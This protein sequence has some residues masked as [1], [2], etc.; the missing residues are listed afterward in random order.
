MLQLVP[1]IRPP[2][3][4]ILLAVEDFDVAALAFQV[5]AVVGQA[6]TAGPGCCRPHDS[7]L[8]RNNAGIGNTVTVCVALL[9]GHRRAAHVGAA[10]ASAGVGQGIAAAAVRADD[11]VFLTGGK[12]VHQLVRRALDRLRRCDRDGAGGCFAAVFR[13]N[14][15]SRRTLGDGRDDAPA[16]G[17]DRRIAAGPG[18]VLIR[19]I[20]RSYR[21]AQRSGLPG[22]KLQRRLIQAD[23]CDR[24][25]TGNGLHLLEQVDL[26]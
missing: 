25:R 6:E 10:A 23:P 1:G 15:D 3:F 24:N 8:T 18:D 22:F 26:L 14:G 2:A 9:D 16:D 12:L 11:Q 20:G 7:G 5:I 13:G 17:S 4:R 21:R 19:G